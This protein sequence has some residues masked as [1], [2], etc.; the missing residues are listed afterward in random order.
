MVILS[1][2]YIV[3]F[4]DFDLPH[5]IFLTLFGALITIVPYIDPF[6]SGII[7]V[8]FAAIYFDNFSA[9]IGFTLIVLVIQ[10]IESYVL[11]PIIIGSEVRLSP[12][13]IIIAILLGQLIWGIAGMILFVPMFAITK[14]ICDHVGSLNPIGYLLGEEHS[15]SQMTSGIKAKIIQWLKK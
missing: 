5:A 7:P 4:L 10:L 14:I 6:L 15:K 2:M 9:V 13:V 8:L 12:L 1:V 3:T 11:E